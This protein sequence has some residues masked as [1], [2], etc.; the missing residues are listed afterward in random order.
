MYFCTAPISR[1]KKSHRRNAHIF[2]CGWIN[3]IFI[4]TVNNFS[5]SEFERTSFAIAAN[6]EAK[7]G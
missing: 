6:H 3:G 7:P 5:A 1:P 2:S 4:E